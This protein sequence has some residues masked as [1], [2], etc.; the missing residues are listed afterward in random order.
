MNDNHEEESKQGCNHE[1]P[2]VMAEL[3]RI[4]QNN[5][6]IARRTDKNIK[7]QLVMLNNEFSD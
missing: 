5:N 2:L 7:E 4:E 6:A 3:K 1:S